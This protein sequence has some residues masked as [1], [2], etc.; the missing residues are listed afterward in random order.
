MN[1]CCQLYS[2]A[3]GGGPEMQILD[4][5]IKAGLVREQGTKKILTFPEKF[6]CMYC[7]EIDWKKEESIV[8]L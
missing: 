1:K 4:P 7:G 8:S 5:Y 2:C 6:K 3:N